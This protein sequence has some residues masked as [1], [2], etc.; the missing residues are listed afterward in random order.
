MKNTAYMLLS[1]LIFRFSTA[2]AFAPPRAMVNGVWYTNGQTA[3]FTCDINSVNVSID[4]VLVSDGNG[5]SKLIGM[6]VQASPN[7]TISTTQSEIQVRLNFPTNR[8]DGFIRVGFKDVSPQEFITINIVQQIPTPTLINI[9]ALCSAGQTA[10]MSAQINYSYQSSFPANLIWQGSGGVTI[11]GSGTFTQTN[12]TSSSVNLQ[13]ASRGLLEV[14]TQVPGCENR[15]STAQSVYFGTPQI[16]DAIINNVANASP[17]GVPSG[18][19][20]FVT[21]RSAFNQN[22]FYTYTT[23]TNFGD[24]RLT[25]NGGGGSGS[26]TVQ[27]AGSTGNAALNITATNSCG[28]DNTSIIFFIPSSFRVA[29]NPAQSNLTVTFSDTE[30]DVALPDQLELVS[31]RQ[32]KSVLSVDVKDIFKRKAFKNGSDIMLDVSRLERGTYYLRAINP[33]LAANKQQYPVRII[34]N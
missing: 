5:G 30:T 3:S 15:R 34:L 8:Q 14:F 13:F 10:S 11:N 25:V 22:P 4:P 6:D 1:L 27:V 32:I 31:E 7:F 33:R 24:I 20:N 26:C 19:L 23:N 12:A 2:A 16:T 18:S 21:V 28:S 29:S 9:P 17:Y